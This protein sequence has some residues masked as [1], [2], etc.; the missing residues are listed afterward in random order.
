M[1]SQS[2]LI[3]VGYVARAHGVRGQV[4]VEGS[5]DSLGQLSRVFLG[6]RDGATGVEVAIESA[7]RTDGGWLVKLRG[8]D[9]RDAADALRG[10]SLRAP[11]DQLP[12]PPDDEVYVADLVGCAVVDGAGAPLGTVKQVYPSGAHELLV[13]ERPDGREGLV[14]FIEPIVLSV[15]IA[16][17]VIVCDPPEGLL[18]P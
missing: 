15:D 11:R 18:D 4:R 12:A 5:S 13:I 3:G 9:D 16:A 1:S 2:P 7:A 14:P 17:R 6:E 10:K 8:V